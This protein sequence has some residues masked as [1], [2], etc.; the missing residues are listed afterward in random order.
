MAFGEGAVVG[1]RG[2]EGVESLGAEGGEAWSVSWGV[3]AGVVVDG[4]VQGGVAVFKV[5]EFGSGGVEAEGALAHLEAY[6][7]DGQGVVVAVRDGYFDLG[8]VLEVGAEDG[9]DGELLLVDGVAG[10]GEVDAGDL[11]AELFGGGARRIC[12]EGLGGDGDGAAEVGVEGFR[13]EE[14]DALDGDAGGDAEGGDGAA[15]F[16]AKS[17]RFG[18]CCV[19]GLGLAAGWD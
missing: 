5:E 7:C 2:V 12:G 18:D 4:G 19:E 17:C 8:V 10:L 1:T 3:Q 11:A 9:R 14:L 15:V 6:G 16:M 13:E